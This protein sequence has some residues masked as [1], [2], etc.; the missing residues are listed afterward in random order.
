[1]IHYKLGV[2]QNIGQ[3]GRLGKYVA[4]GLTALCCGVTVAGGLATKVPTQIDPALIGD[5]EVRRVLMN[6]PNAQ[7]SMREDDPRLMAR[8]LRIT[9]DSVSFARQRKCAASPMIGGQNL[10]MR[11]LFAKGARAKRPAAMKRTLYE[12]LENYEIGAMR[13]EAEHGTIDHP[14]G[15]I[16]NFELSKLSGRPVKLLETRCS[17]RDGTFFS[18]FNWIAVVSGTLPSSKMAT[19]LLP[20]Q[21]DALLVLRRTP[22]IVAPGPAQIQ[23]CKSAESA[24]DKAICADR[25]L[26]LMQAYTLSA[27]PFAQPFAHSNLPV[28]QAQLDARITEALRKRQDCNGDPKCLY[29]VLDDHIETLVQRW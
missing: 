28:V 4:A 7:W 27:Q 11:A 21:P 19:V 8:T 22:T 25:Q 29:E 10:P 20:Y 9:A 5:W 2:A 16:G 18:G 14:V 23:Y 24:S 15:R 3:G 13:P 17:D 1:M 26:W 12:R 6:G